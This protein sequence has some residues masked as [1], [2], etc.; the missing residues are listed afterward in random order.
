MRLTPAEINRLLDLRIRDVAGRAPA[1]SL[2]EH[3]L[4]VRQDRPKLFRCLGLEPF[5]NGGEMLPTITGTLQ[6]NGY[7]IEKLAYYSRP[8]FPVT[9]HLYLPE[10]TGRVPVIIRPHGHWRGKKSDPVVQASAV[11]LVL[12]GYAVLVIDAPGDANEPWELNERADQGKHDDPWLAMGTPLEGFYVWDMMRGIDYLATRP[13][14]AMDKIGI[15]GASGG[16]A[17]AMYAFAA[18]ERI[19][20]AAVVCFAS[21]L[22]VQPHNGCLCNHVP[23]ILSLGD[24]SDVLALRAPAPLLLVG[25]SDDP[26][27]PAKGMHRTQEKLAAVYRRFDRAPAPRLEI[28]ESL[29]DYNRRMRESVLAF[30][31]EHLML[32]ERRHYRAEARPITDGAHNPCPA[33]TVPMESGEMLVLPPG[34]REDT[35]MRQFL[36]RALQ[37]SGNLEFDL[38]ARLAPWA[39]YGRLNL[40]LDSPTLS[41]VDEELQLPDLDLRTCIYLGMSVFEVYAQIL[42]IMLPG[43]IEGWESSTLGPGGDVVSSLIGSMKALIGASPGSATPEEVRA[44]GPVSSMIARFLQVYRPKLRI[45]ISHEAQN[46]EQL[47]QMGAPGLVQPLARYLRWPLPP[48]E[49]RAPEIRKELRPEAV[50]EGETDEP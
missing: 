37:S 26:E 12:A 39:K 36:E 29:H 16:G 9:A 45:E 48:P 27:F 42:H 5:P 6:R 3:L 15:T 28:V 24:R 2:Q 10:A 33:E 7:R 46:W 41:L 31:D 13:E 32:K 1:N 22:E 21:S 50:V 35:T 23:N 49:M 38:P 47:Y 43:G 30:F 34:G 11:G 17:A 20:C 8:N 14:I 44:A 18:D 4:R 19:A 40:A 25:A